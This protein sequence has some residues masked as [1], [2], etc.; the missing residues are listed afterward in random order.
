MERVMTGSV[1][2]SNSSW[3]RRL[4]RPGSNRVVVAGLRRDCRVGSRSVGT[5]V[6]EGTSITRTDV[7]IRRR[8]SCKGVR[9]AVIDNRIGW[10]VVNRLWRWCHGKQIVIVG[11]FTVR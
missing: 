9:L 5:L 7:G 4:G 6:T 1:V 8:G 11:V 10:V 3:E 2:A